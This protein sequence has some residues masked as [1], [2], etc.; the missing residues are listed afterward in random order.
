MQCFILLKQVVKR[1]VAKDESIRTASDR[2]LRSF[3]CP[4][5]ADTEGDERSDDGS[6]G[7]NSSW[8]YF[9]SHSGLGRFCE[10]FELKKSELKK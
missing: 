4:V 6:D 10:K 5:H 8:N 3:R 7:V 9:R 2:N 1:R